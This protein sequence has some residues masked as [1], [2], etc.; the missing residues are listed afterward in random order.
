MATSS[1]TL[2]RGTLLGTW[3]LLVEVSETSSVFMLVLTG[4]FLDVP[5]CRGRVLCTVGV[6][7]TCADV[8]PW[9]LRL[10]VMTRC[11]GR[12]VFNCASPI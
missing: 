3:L 4:C 9:T 2:R 7:H 5:Y 1:D 10:R 12:Q 11:A 6:Q 8:G